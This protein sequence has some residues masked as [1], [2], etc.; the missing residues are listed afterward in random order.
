MQVQHLL[1]T[2]KNGETNKIYKCTCPQRLQ[3]IIEQTIKTTNIWI[4]TILVSPFNLISGENYKNVTLGKK[5]KMHVWGI[6]PTTLGFPRNHCDLLDWMRK[7]ENKIVRKSCLLEGRRKQRE[8]SQLFI[9][10][11]FLKKNIVIFEIFPNKWKFSRLNLD[12]TMLSRTFA[13]A[14]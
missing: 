12:I 3:S 5:R 10:S 6:E 8:V 4:L 11:T 9:S 2:R 14:L 13:R 1:V 7:R